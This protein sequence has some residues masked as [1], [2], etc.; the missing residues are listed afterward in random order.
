VEALSEVLRA[1]KLT[2]AVTS[3]GLALA[4]S[5]LRSGSATLARIA[6]AVGYESEVAFNRAFK[7]AFGVPPARW[8]RGDG[9]TASN[10]PR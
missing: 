1:V 10:P 5:R 8:R 9:V 2:G 6:E 7:R 4:A 3:W